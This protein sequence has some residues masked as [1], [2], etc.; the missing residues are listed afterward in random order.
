MDDSTNTVRSELLP[1]SMNIFGTEFTANV[2]SERRADT[3][4]EAPPEPI[5]IQ[6]MRGG[7]ASDILSEALV[8]KTVA[9]HKGSDANVSEVARMVRGEFAS[10]QRV[11]ETRIARYDAT[12]DV[13]FEDTELIIY[14]LETERDFENIL[15]FCEIENAFTR[16]AIVELMQ[17][18]AT[19][20]AEAISEYPL[21]VR[22]PTAFRAGERHARARLSRPTHTD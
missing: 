4:G 7:D 5:P 13:V 15:D 19:D 9:E 22:K 8:R 21:V 2:P 1:H 14:R 3:G 11:L 16:R 6:T 17:A 10:L 20:R 18:I 12:L